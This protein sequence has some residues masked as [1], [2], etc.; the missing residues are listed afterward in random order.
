MASS[1][2]VARANTWRSE[3]H[4]RVITAYHGVKIVA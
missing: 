2:I 1:M 4:H 3:G